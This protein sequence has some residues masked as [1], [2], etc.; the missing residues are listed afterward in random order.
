VTG[1][2][3]I[4]ENQMIGFFE[5]QYL[6]F[7][8]NHIKNLLALARVDGDIHPKE[9]ALLFRIGKRYGLKDRQ[10]RQIIESDEKHTVNIPDNH[11]DKMN[12]IYDLL[13]MIHADEK[14]V[15]NE[16]EFFEE[17]IH[18]FGMKKEMVSWL[19]QV[20]EKKGTPPPPDDW[21]DIKLEAKEKFLLT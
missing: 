4:T 16:I 12:L 11:N 8:K 15:E 7:R 19:L 18:N 14:V 9:E 3:S 21:E 20:F 17:A 1:Y 10:I 13:L 5:H 6:S 2:A